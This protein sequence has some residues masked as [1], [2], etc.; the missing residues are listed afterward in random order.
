MLMIHSR[1]P[2]PIKTVRGYWLDAEHVDLKTKW[3][4]HEPTASVLIYAD[5]TISL[6]KQTARPVKMRLKEWA[7]VL[8]L[9]MLWEFGN[10]RRETIEG[11]VKM[12]LPPVDKVFL[13]REYHAGRLLMAGYE[14]LIKRDAG[15]SS[16]E[17]KQLG[18]KDVLKIYE[19]RE[20]TVRK[21]EPTSVRMLVRFEFKEELRDAQYEGDEESNVI[22]RVVSDR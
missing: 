10:L 11:L 7:S 13:G 19:A 14:E 16:V 22:R 2:E 15:L 6:N 3:H 17:K 4:L 21:R 5:I 12:K 18:E 20:K 1:S 8:K 9:S